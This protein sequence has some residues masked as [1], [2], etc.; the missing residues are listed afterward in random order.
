MNSDSESAADG[1]VQSPSLLAIHFLIYRV[2]K[3]ITSLL[4]QISNKIL[5]GIS[6]VDKTTTCN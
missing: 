1:H 3:L 4:Y 2:I 5:N 6:P